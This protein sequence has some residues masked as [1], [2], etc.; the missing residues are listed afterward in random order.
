MVNNGPAHEPLLTALGGDP[1]SLEYYIEHELDKWSENKITPLFV[2]DG[3]SIIGKD[4]MTL[5]NSRAALLKTQLAWKLYGDHQP[6][7]AVK[8]FGSSDATRIHDLYHILQKVLLKRGLPFQ[9]A[10]F[11][12]CAQLVYLLDLEF[13]GKGFI[14]GIMGSK[15]MLLYD[16]SP[17][18]VIICPPTT[19]DWDSKSFRG[20][21]RY[22][23][24]EK[25]CVNSEMLDDALLMAGTSF[26][27]TFPPLRTDGIITQQPFTLVDAINLLRTSEKSITTTCGQFSDILEKNDPK[28]LDKF[29][30]AKIGILHA[31]IIQPDGQVISRDYA[32]LTSDNNDY[33]GLQLPPELYF[34]LSKALIGPR[35][36]NYF[37]S[38]ESIIF[39]TLDGVVSDEYK[40]LV[41]KSLIPLRE[42]AAALVAFRIHRV[43]QN[44]P[45]TMRFWFD[46]SLRQTLVHKGMLE[47]VNGKA[48]TWGVRNEKFEAWQTLLQ[49]EPVSLSFAVLSLAMNG[50]P[51]QTRVSTKIVGLKTKSE[52][53][54]NTLY[55]FL[56]LR[57]YVDDQHELTTWGKALATTIKNIQPIIK[58]QNDIYH[59][60]E[61][62][63]LAFEMIRFDVLNS[64]NRHPELIGGALRG[65]E[66]D[67]ANCML[68]GRTTCLLKF[69]HKNLGY[70]GPL[71]KNFLAYN[72]LVKAVRETDRDILESVI[73]S[74]FLSN[75]ISRF[76]N[77]N[78]G[79]LGRSL[80]FT[81]SINTIFGIAVTTYLDDYFKS[82][83]TP[84]Q[85]E[86][87]KQS[88][89]EKFIPNSMMFSE[90]LAASFE[91]FD[92][93]YAGVIT[94]ADE[95]SAADKEAW[96]RANKYLKERR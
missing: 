54:S 27:P 47:Q 9:I 50:I 82:E 28:W 55:R 62:A 69:R 76:E 90:D 51:A 41:T 6:N 39:P 23:L 10:P 80:P 61:A 74:M 24:M 42:A 95:I 34:Y 92:A 1:I 22:E 91:F 49:I 77:H 48:D 38:L 44:K 75:Q 60:E 59:A 21:F 79:D 86:Q 73:V 25:L 89:A 65:S 78:Y 63:L 19:S 12:A 29:Q 53:L 36:L 40:K 94:L 88:F 58:I 67:K 46:S 32:N 37:I 30:K 43:F 5:R 52:I 8:T 87:N 14:D 66:E 7:D 15:E 45:V 18:A 35:I 96:D 64:Q 11:S 4:E 56:H 31:I 13:S 16:R 17:E 84:D 68:V 33:L 71:S 20:I 72:S 3:Q 85:R 2:F 57:G 81:E 83:W 93:V 70:T 26:L